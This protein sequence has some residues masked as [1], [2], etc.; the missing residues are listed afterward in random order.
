MPFFK[1]SLVA[2]TILVGAVTAPANAASII[3][4]AGN[5][6]DLTE[7]LHANSAGHGNSLTLKSAPGQLLVD[8]IST[9]L[10]DV[11]NGNGVAQIDGFGNP[12]PGFLDVTLDPNSFAAFGLVHLKIDGL[13]WG[14]GNNKSAADNFDLRVNFLGG[15]FEDFFNVGLNASN[16]YLI[17]GDGNLISSLVFTDM[18]ALNGE[19][20]LFRSLKQISFTA[21]APPPAIPEPASWAMMIG[22]FA[23]AGGVLRSRKTVT[24]FA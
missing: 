15:G 14:S 18:R 12:N 21:A 13:A 19:L 24:A 9:T 20:T 4:I 10:I 3:Q 6:P 16:K 23:L 2:A 1:S 11:G 8:A 17:S 22:G 5:L 7:I